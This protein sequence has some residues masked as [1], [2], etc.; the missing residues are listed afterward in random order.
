MVNL[1]PHNILPIDVLVVVLTPTP[2]ARAPGA[3][4]APQAPLHVPQDDL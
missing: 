4:A 2:V 3:G 1:F